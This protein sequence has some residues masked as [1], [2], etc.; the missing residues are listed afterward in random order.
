MIT[1]SLSLS[2]PFI[3]IILERLS[4]EGFEIAVVFIA[5]GRGKVVQISSSSQRGILWGVFEF[6]GMLQRKTVTDLDHAPIMST[7]KMKLRM[8]DLWD[9]LNGL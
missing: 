4:A 6:L 3:I 9:N 2:L 7:P 8:W 1:F 5:G